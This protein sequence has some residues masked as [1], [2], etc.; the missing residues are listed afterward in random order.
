MTNTPQFKSPPLPSIESF[1]LDNIL[2]TSLANESNQVISDLL[3]ITNN[4]QQDLAQGIKTNLIIE[5]KIQSKNVEV[6][7]LAHGISSQLK[8]RVKKLNKVTG[9][10]D[11]VNKLLRNTVIV[12][13]KVRSLVGQL[14]EIEMLVNGSVNPSVYPNIYKILQKQQRL[15]AVDQSQVEPRPSVES[16][17]PARLSPTP[18]HAPIPLRAAEAPTPPPPPPPPPPKSPEQSLSE[19]E[20]SE[21]I[22][23]SPELPS[24]QPPETAKDI[25]QS[26]EPEDMDPDQFELFMSESISKYRHRQ[27]LKHKQLPQ[28]PPPINNPLNLLYSQL[29]PKPSQQFLKSP[30]V[31]SLPM[32]SMPIIKPTLQ[33]SHFKKLRINGDPIGST[34]HDGCG[35]NSPDHSEQELVFQDDE[36]LDWKGL[37]CDEE[38]TETDS[39]ESDSDDD[40]TSLPMMTNQYYKNLKRASRKRTRNPPLPPARQPELSPTP[41]HK[42]SH[43]TLK[44]KRSILKTSDRIVFSKEN[45]PYRQA[46]KATNIIPDAVA[47]V[48]NKYAS[49]IEYPVSEFTAEGVIIE[50]ETVEADDSSSI[51]SISVLKSYIN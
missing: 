46:V 4:Y 39:S 30:F 2:N 29:I 50:P 3:N 44:P 26:P 18:P 9:E 37:S 38:L 13:D 6:V 36:E 43:H 20:S 15:Q 40:T 45:S 7:K 24:R 32:K 35:C 27:S 19:S 8:S 48:N 49:R 21:I 10:S 25:P 42:P 47:I 41:K 31:N 23:Y 16:P 33:T 51:R 5:Q 17:T 14:H 12:S 11:E 34:K 1:K 28:S 22:P